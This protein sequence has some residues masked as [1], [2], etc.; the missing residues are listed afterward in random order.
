MVHAWNTITVFGFDQSVSRSAQTLVRDVYACV[1]G[2][3]TRIEMWTAA[4]AGG[5]VHGGAVV[6]LSTR[7][8]IKIQSLDTGRRVIGFPQY[9]HKRELFTAII[10]S[11]TLHH[12]YS[13]FGPCQ[14]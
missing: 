7:P 6:T 3:A 13:S 2:K 10:P 1:Y 5:T 14:W 4:E 9:P 8:H 12:N 11:P